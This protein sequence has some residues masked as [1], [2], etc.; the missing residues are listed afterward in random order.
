M[1]NYVECLCIF[2]SSTF[3]MPG[4]LTCSAFS[5][6]FI[7]QRHA[8]ERM[9]SSLPCEGALVGTFH[10]PSLERQTALCLGNTPKDSYIFFSFF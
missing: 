6:A 8:E 10:F 5:E 9:A 3:E 1:Q 2:T 4:I 7:D